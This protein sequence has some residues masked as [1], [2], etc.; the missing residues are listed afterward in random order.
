MFRILAAF[1]VSRDRGPASPE[2]AH[3]L[4]PTDEQDVSSVPKGRRDTPVPFAIGRLDGAPVRV[5]DDSISRAQPAD[6][7][8]VHHRDPRKGCA[9]RDDGVCALVHD[10]RGSV[11]PLA[12]AV[13][14]VR[15]HG[16]PFPAREGEDSALHAF[17]R[18]AGR[19]IKDR[20]R[21]RVHTAD[22]RERSPGSDCLAGRP[23]RYNS[24]RADYHVYRSSRVSTSSKMTFCL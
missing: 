9:D 24:T 22:E 12:E 21:G 13:Y 11:A 10:R 6:I 15:T 7:D 5:D 16:A 3:L 23:A 1:D 19:V 18:H 14:H 2:G 8:A 17:A 4:A 20:S